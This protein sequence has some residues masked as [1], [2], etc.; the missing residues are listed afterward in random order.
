M[1]SKI[2]MDNQQLSLQSGPGHNTAKPQ[3]VDEGEV[4]NWPENELPQEFRQEQLRE[5]TGDEREHELGGQ[6]LFSK[7]VD[8]EAPVVLAP[9][10]SSSSSCSPGGIRWRSWFGKGPLMRANGKYS[11]VRT[12]GALVVSSALG[13]CS[14]SQFQAM[15]VERGSG[16]RGIGNEVRPAG[17]EVDLLGVDQ[18]GFGPSS[19]YY[20]MNGGLAFPIESEGEER[21]VLV[22]QRLFAS[23]GGGK[24]IPGI[25][26]RELHS[27]DLQSDRMLGRTDSG[28]TW[29]VACAGDALVGQAMAPEGLNR[30][31][32]IMYLDKQVGGKDGGGEFWLVGGGTLGFGVLGIS[33]P[34]S[35]SS[36]RGS[37]CASMVGGEWVVSLLGTIRSEGGIQEVVLQTYRNGIWEQTPLSVLG[38]GDQLI[39]SSARS[40]WDS[41]AGLSLVGSYASERGD[42]GGMF[43]WSGGRVEWLKRNESGPWWESSMDFVSGGSQAL[44]VMD[45]D[46]LGP[47]ILNL[48]DA[49]IHIQEL[50]YNGRRTNLSL[51]FSDTAIQGVRVSPAS[52]SESGEEYR[53]NPHSIG[54]PHDGFRVLGLTRTREGG[55]GFLLTLSRWDGLGGATLLCEGVRVGDT[56][57]ITSCVAVP[58][59]HNVDAAHAGV[60]DRTD[61]SML[62]VSPSQSPWC[63]NPT[64]SPSGGSFLFLE[65][66]DGARPLTWRSMDAIQLFGGKARALARH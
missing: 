40:S 3:C 39:A 38:K 41:Q 64:R 59:M 32:V 6:Q 29:F 43:R 18:S 46:S 20:W 7:N 9:L 52:E 60:L 56:I 45:F 51:Q 13:L 21:R 36:W 49:E 5:S 37:V 63:E 2:D 23:S 61:G 26:V 47:K 55:R 58:G 12:L 66:S 54:I 11:A 24:P 50:A 27:T 28:S 35:F 4:N 65:L 14:C 25:G 16:D 53:L 15:V 8:M 62:L 30:L 17:G 1:K 57:T 44:H 48:A 19:K 42:Q 33:P 10:V 22:L 31:S 34:A